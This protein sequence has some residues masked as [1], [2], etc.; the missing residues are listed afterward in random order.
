MPQETVLITG[1][2]G[3]IGLSVL[4]GLLRAGYLVRAAVR[5]KSKAQWLASRVQFM[6]DVNGNDVETI[7]VPDFTSVRAFDK[8]VS[9]TE[10]IVH[11]ASPITSTDNEEDWQRDFVDTA[12]QGS[13]GLL[14]TAVRAGS[15]KRVIFT[16]SMVAILPLVNLFKIPSSSPLDAELRSAD[17]QSPYPAKMMAYATGKIAALNAAEAWIKEKRPQFDIIHM[18]PSFVT[19]YDRT[20]TTAKE[21]CKG[22]N[23]HTL[24]IILGTNHQVGKPALTCHIDDV[25]RCHVQGL[26]PTIPGN[27]CYLISTDGSDESVWDDARDTVQKR[28]PTFV[29]SGIL[30]NNGTM[31]AIKTLLDVG[32]TEKVFGFKHIQFEDQV[33]EIVDQ[34]LHLLATDEHRLN[35]G[36]DLIDGHAAVELPIERKV[37]A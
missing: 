20:V 8:A 36:C 16:S 30:P 18:C 26:N 27:Q 28:F 5:S 15:V 17:M 33:V 29:H 31:P 12:V 21:L 22:S 9:R 19:G 1:A 3:F 11:V 32:K 2:T 13:I 25:V 7:V 6:A 24:S 37:A 14:E 34:Y 4:H 35:S 23:W 10:Y